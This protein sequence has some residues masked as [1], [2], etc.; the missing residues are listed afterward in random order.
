MD[1]GPLV[2][3]FILISL[4]ELGDKTMI[5]VITLSSKR[6]KLEVFAG[7]MLALIALTAMGVVVGEILFQTVPSW[8]VGLAAGI[9]FILFG[10]L[11]LSRPEKEEAKRETYRWGGFLASFGL[12][13][14]MELGDRSQISVVTL[15]AESGE[16]LLVFAG[17]VLGFLWLTALGAYFGRAVG[18]RVP[19]RYVRIGSGLVILVFGALFL[20]RLL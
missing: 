15:A 11:T 8:V 5:A 17:A 4:T 9:V 19:K 6:S 20:L 7:A 3:S 13:A 12:V 1:L 10:A 2:S 18:E 16:A 14:L